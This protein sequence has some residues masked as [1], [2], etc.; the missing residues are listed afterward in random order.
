MRLKFK[1]YPDVLKYI[2][3]VTNYERDAARYT[4]REYNL[5]TIRRMMERVGNPHRDYPIVHVAGTKGKGSVCLM[6]RAMLLARR[7]GLY[8]SPH[9]VDMLE[10]IQVG[11][12][13]VTR[14]EF[15]RSMNRIAPPFDCTYFELM[16]AAAFEIFSRKRVGVGVIEVGLGGR[17]D[18][19]N[20]VEPAV[21]VIN[22]IDYDHMDKLGHTLGAIASEKAGIIKRGVPVVVGPQRPAARRV[23]FQTARRLRAPVFEVNRALDLDLPRHQ[24]MNAALA[25]QAATLLGGPFDVEALNSIHLPGRFDIRG[26]FIFDVAHNAVSARALAASLT[27]A[28]IR[29]VTLV[30]GTSKD[31]D[32]RA[33]LRTLWPFAKRVI[34]TR[35]Q[36]P[37]AFE[38][39]ALVE[40]APGPA[41]T[42]PDVKT[43]VDQARGRTLIT[44][45]F[46]VVGEALA[47]LQT[48]RI[49]A[50]MKI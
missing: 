14:A 37:R 9:L 47:A 11:D 26:R 34:L 35:A 19:T 8:T 49:A 32:A 43:A 33:M 40:L 7:P 46:Y 29:D 48:K 2:N 4:P 25:L 30:F 24:C 38:P 42:A 18:T 17:L 22:T 27:Q 36:S 41:E 16:T 12:R 44:G 15:V 13:P 10:R 3:A 31:K 50:T 5:K 39:A 1:S 45:S 6:L 23:I 28:G 20:I 21:C